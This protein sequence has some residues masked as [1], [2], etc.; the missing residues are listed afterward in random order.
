M[1]LDEQFDWWERQSFKTNCP[2]SGEIH[3]FVRTVR[4]EDQQ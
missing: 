3:S 2:C 1:T 4:D